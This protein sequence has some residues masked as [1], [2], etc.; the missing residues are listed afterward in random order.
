ME[1]LTGAQARATSR[2]IIEAADAARHE[3]ARDLHDGAQQ[4]L[5][6]CLTQLQRAQHKWSTDPDRAKQLVDE[7]VSAIAS[8]LVSLRELAAGI[9]PPLLTHRGLA[10]AIDELASR[11]SL[12]V[13]LDVT[14]ER[15]PLAF[16]ASVFFFISEALSNVTKHATASAASIRIHVDGDRVTVEVIDNGV[17]GARATSEGTGLPGLVDRVAALGGTLNIAS[18]S[19]N[20]TRLSAEMPVPR[21]G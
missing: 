10:A 14:G 6:V 15:F 2:R 4:R 8:A 16:E 7:G 19:G 18:D 3:V 5:I 13:A 1:P 11:Q 17:G 20:G 12:P 9:H 21:A